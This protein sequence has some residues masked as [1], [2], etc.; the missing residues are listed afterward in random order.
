MLTHLKLKSNKAGQRFAMFDLEDLTGKI[1]CFVF[2]RVFEQVRSHLEDDAILVMRGTVRN[3]DG[4]A[5]FNANDVAGLKMIQSLG[6]P[7]TRGGGV[8]ICSN[9]DVDIYEGNG[10][11][12]PEC[13]ETPEEEEAL[14]SSEE[15]ES[16]G[17]ILPDVEKTLI[18]RIYLNIDPGEKGKTE[19]LEVRKILARY[20]GRMRLLVIIK[21]ADWQKNSVL[22]FPLMRKCLPLWNLLL[23]KKKC[24][25]KSS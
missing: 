8:N 7:T 1:H 20:P 4:K 21:P 9:E 16:L 12:L 22:Q 15:N 25:C 3:E 18:K 17:V 11:S 13:P 5:S 24:V 23:G 10:L 2:A 19:E 14:P 6:V